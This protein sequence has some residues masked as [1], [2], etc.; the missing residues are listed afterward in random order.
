VQVFHS[1]QKSERPPFWNGCSCS[2]KNG[3]VDVT[4]KGTSFLLNFI[5]IYELV[6]KFMGE[7]HT[8]RQTHR[9]DGDLISLR[10]SFSK[11]SRVKRDY[12][13]FLPNPSYSRSDSD[14]KIA[15]SR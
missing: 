3:G 5:K 1:P 14:I 12:V 9:Q 7:R 6:Q 15:Y 4:F 10:F 13:I 11:E 2:I 8:D